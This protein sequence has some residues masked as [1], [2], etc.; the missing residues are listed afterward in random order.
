MPNRQGLTGPWRFLKV[1]SGFMIAPMSDLVHLATIELRGHQR[2]FTAYLQLL[3]LAGGDGVA[4]LTGGVRGW[5]E[6]LGCSPGWPRQLLSDLEE[7]GLIGVEFYPGEGGL[8][9]EVDLRPSADRSLIESA[10]A[11]PEPEP[12]RGSHQDAEPRSA[13]SISD[14]SPP[15]PPHVEDHDSMCGGGGGDAKADNEFIDQVVEQDRPVYAALRRLGVGYPAALECA[16]LATLDQIARLEDSARRK[17]ADDVAAWVVDG[18]RN[19]RGRRSALANRIAQRRQEAPLAVNPPRPPRDPNDQLRSAIRAQLGE[20]AERPAA[21]ASPAPAPPAGLR[22]R[23]QA[24]QGLLKSQVTP[25]EFD[26]WLRW[27]D[28]VELAGG[29]AVVRAPSAVVAA[30]VRQRY[31]SLIRRVLGDLEATPVQLR[32]EPAAAAAD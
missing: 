7:R 1:L 18:I 13:D 2:K 28:L 15:T 17:P 32:V 23:W 27:L 11:E 3:G 21:R 24:A 20:P 29:A 8:V 12:E 6:A 31:A 19:G 10:P 25:G 14:R 5:A 16:P 26:T 22:Q 30:T 9:A 4:V